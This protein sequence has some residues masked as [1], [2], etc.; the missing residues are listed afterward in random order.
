MSTPETNCTSC[1]DG[2]TNPNPLDACT[3]SFMQCDNP[4]HIAQHNT[5]A[6]ESLPS[7]IENFT[8]NFFGDVIRTEVNGQVV[9]SLP[10]GLDVGLPANPRG[11]DEGLA[12]YFL[13]MF[14]DGIVGLQGDP[15]AP[16][17]VGA[18]GHNAYTVTLAAFVTPA[19]GQTVQVQTLYNPGILNQSYL[20]VDTSGWYQVVGTTISGLLTLKLLI[21]APGSGVTPAGKLAVPSGQPGQSITGAKGDKGD[22]GPIGP[23]GPQGLQG[24]TGATGPA[25]NNFLTNNGYL[26]GFGGSDFNIPTNAGTFSLI[27]FG[28]GGSMQFTATNVGT[29]FI[30]AS[31]DAVN[32]SGGSAGAQF[33]LHNST[34]GVDL[35]GGANAIG[36]F[37]A[38]QEYPV[39]LF[40][41]YQNTVLNQVIQLRASCFNSAAST[42][43]VVAN[44]SAMMF[45]QIG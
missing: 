24:N 3:R 18:A 16:G 13:R 22:T 14:N 41:I 2:G 1:G 20:L 5:V 31:F 9:W 19:V 7:R 29:Y 40:A 8:K 39:T 21:A 28:G 4:C 36:A 23:V 44:R 42:V 10:C 12:C 11:A 15:G 26:T 45:F 6:C 33:Q 32:V 38:N 25:G 37:V 17:A 27:N 43:S 34:A 35:A 30:A